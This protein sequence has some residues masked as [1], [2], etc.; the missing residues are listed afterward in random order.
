MAASFI[1]D[2]NVD[3][4]F[5]FMPLSDIINAENDFIKSNAPNAKRIA[6]TEDNRRGTERAQH[7][8]VRC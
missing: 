1:V 5:D 7:I 4:E 6:S 2:R 8:S 3:F